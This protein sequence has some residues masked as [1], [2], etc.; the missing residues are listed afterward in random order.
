MTQELLALVTGLAHYLKIL[1]RIALTGALRLEREQSVDEA[2]TSFLDKLHLLVVQGG[3]PSARRVI[4][5]ANGGVLPASQIGNTGTQG[6]TYGFRSLAPEN[7]GDSP[8]A[9]STPREGM[10]KAPANV[11]PS[12]LCVK[13]NVTVEEDCVRLGTYQRWHSH[14][15]RCESCGRIAAAPTPPAPKS[16]HEDQGERDDKVKVKGKDGS[17]VSTV[18]RPPADVDSFIFDI[19]QGKDGADIPPVIL[20]VDHGHQGCRSGFQAVSRL[21]QY[22]YLL[23]VALRRLY[24]L[25][26]KQGVV[27][28]SPGAFRAVCADVVLTTRWSVPSPGSAQTPTDPDFYRNSADIVT[29]MKSVH[30]YRKSSA[31][32]RIPKRSTVIESPTGKSAHHSETLRVQRSQE[33]GISQPPRSAPQIS[34]APQ[35]QQAQPV[36]QG[37]RSPQPPSKSPPQL[38]STPRL[39]PDIP[40]FVQQGQALRP[41]FS[42]NN[43]EVKIV[44]DNAPT[45]S[46]FDEPPVLTPA[47][48]G[49]TLADIPQLM[50]VAQAREQQRSLPRENS[51]PYIAELS[52]V[53][54]AIVKHAAV[55]VLHRSPMKD[56]FDLDEI[57]E[58]L[59]VKKG[60]FWNKL[61]KPGNNKNNVK[62]KGQS[63]SR[64]RPRPHST[65]CSLGVFGVPLELLVEKEGVDSLLGAT[66]TALRIPSFIDDII[67]AMR[68]IGQWTTPCIL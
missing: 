13:C 5:S 40:D 60:G 53:E 3:N 38:Y 39:V 27:P 48:T 21:E 12:D 24:L 57:L 58:S 46:A 55:L 61:F 16:D 66:H 64:R 28:L 52:P 32:A 18:R 51:I 68:Q 29:T 56:Y 65:D 47:D 9:S 33:L 25:L 43:T 23:N 1:I 15:V 62:K 17:K 59:E 50:E 10:G 31:S 63:S 6:V 14:C 44:D 45:P 7:A 34:Y 22:A 4:K 41:A 35:A 20:C 19:H 37:Q 11:P 49:I 67:S 54:L 36:Q 42:R 30:I 26:K 2:M 8:F